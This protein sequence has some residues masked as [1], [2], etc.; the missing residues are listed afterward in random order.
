MNFAIVNLGC[1]V[2]RAESD[3]ASADLL[4][5]GHTLSLLDEANL[6][7]VNTCTVT[8]EAE[9][10]TRKALSRILRESAAEQVLVTGCAAA[11]NP[12][13][14]ESTSKRVR[15]IPKSELSA[16]IAQFGSNDKTSPAL[17]RLG[18][19][20][21][22][23]VGVKIQDGCNNACTYCIVH[24]ARGRIW[25]KNADEVVTECKSLASAGTKEIVLTGINLG[26]YECEGMHLA[27]LMHRLL[28]ATKDMHEEGEL[29]CRFRISSIEPAD[30]SE[31]LIEC[32]ASSTG[33]ICK[34]LHLP[35]QSGSSKVLS[36]MAR[37]Y[38]ASEYFF[39][40]ERL[41]KAMPTLSLSSDIIVGFPG[42]SESDFKQSLDAA[43]ACA[44]SKIH[45]FPYSKRKGTPAAA[46]LDQ[47]SAEVKKER[48]AHLRKVALE[49]RNLDFEKR[50]GAKEN[51]LVEQ[52]GR[53]MTESYYEIEAPTKMPIGALI[54][55]DIPNKRLN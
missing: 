16:H 2:N 17:L 30:V 49:L 20:F 51:V 25:S 18:K 15:V 31:E 6:V 24:V 13:F 33:R 1:K 52:L 29:A 46:R 14:Y 5:Q 10:K 12:E 35:L 32:I 43:H 37:P 26:S 4:A 47:I 19:N 38:N 48:A 45:V 23:R 42:E 40:V 44:F 3:A 36:E 9:K 21:P 7:I 41:R 54:S 28:E 27:Q 34:H 11:I 22:T 8:S 39:L 53:A 50:I 55:I